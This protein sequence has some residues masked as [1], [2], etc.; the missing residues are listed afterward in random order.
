MQLNNVTMPS[1]YFSIYTM[2]TNFIFVL[3]L[4]KQNQPNLV[5]QNE[6]KKMIVMEFEKCTARTRVS[7]NT[8]AHQLG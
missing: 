7:P 2:Q 8:K 5:T 1:I 4:D 3:L 6:L